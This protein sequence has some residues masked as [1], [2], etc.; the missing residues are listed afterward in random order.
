MGHVYKSVVLNGEGQFPPPSPTFGK[1]L[2]TF[3]VVTAVGESAM[4]IFYVQ[5]RDVVNI[6]QCNKELSSQQC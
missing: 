4:G 5:S 3:L 2:E 6:L 1:A